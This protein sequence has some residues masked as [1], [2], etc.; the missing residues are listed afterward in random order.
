MKRNEALEE[1]VSKFL[2]MISKMDGYI[3]QSNE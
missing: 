1:I 3:S 2:M